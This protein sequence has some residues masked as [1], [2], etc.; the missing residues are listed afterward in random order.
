MSEPV[1]QVD[2]AL[3][4]EERY[5]ALLKIAPSVLHD[6]PDWTAC[7]ATSVTLLATHL[8]EF[9]WIGFYRVIEPS[10]LAIGPYRGTLGCLTIP[11]SKGVCGKAAREGRTVLVP[12]V[13]K[14]EDHI[15]CDDASKSEIVVPLFDREGHLVGVLDV[16]SKRVE[17]FED[18]D[19]EALEKFAGIMR[20]ALHRELSDDE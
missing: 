15:A 2:P 17:D 3:P 11:F 7:M 10:L 13:T 5:A 9:F 19:R 20:E 14:F 16:D 4:R 18:D 1:L 6:S 8:P 12:D